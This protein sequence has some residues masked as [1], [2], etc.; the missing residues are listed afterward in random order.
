M[1]HTGGELLAAQLVAEG[2][3][4]VFG[5][6]GIQLDYAVDGLA[7][8]ADQIDF[9]VAR[10]EQG[11]AYM[12]DGYARVSD[13][14]GVCLVV[15][16][17]GL[18]NAGAALSTA[19]ATSSRVVMIVGQIPSP[20]I[21]AGLGMLH[22][23]PEQSRLIASLTKWHRLVTDAADIPAAVNEAFRQVQSGRPR[24]VAIEVPPDV[25]KTVATAP[26]LPAAVG[27]PLAPDAGQIA[28]LAAQLSAA[29]R[30]VIYVG[31]GIRDIPAATALQAVAEALGAPIV[32]SRNGRGAVS[33]RHPLAL[34]RLAG[35][36]ALDAA[37]F[38]LAV[39]TRFM[40]QQGR[41]VVHPGRHRIAAINAEAADLAAPRS[42]GLAL[43]ADARLA[44][45]ALLPQ[46]AP[47]T[48]AAAEGTPDP[49]ELR[50]RA[51]RLLDEVAP[52]RDW[53]LAIRAGLPDDGV[54]VDELTQVGYPSRIAY[55]VYTPGSYVTPG[56]QGTLGYGFPTALGVQAA[57]PDRP[58]VSINGDGGFGWALQEL[59]TAA[60]YRLGLVTIVFENGVFGNVERIQQETFG[61]TVGV[62]LHNPD[63]TLLGE[64]FGVA[65]RTV[66]T[67]D[68]LTAVIRDHAGVREPLLVVVPVTDFPTP[69]DLIA[70]PSYGDAN[71]RGQA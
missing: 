42:F 21:D 43:H 5:V 63:Y 70:E 10:H 53:L 12:A 58:V 66:R 48:A 67:P 20:T 56:Y 54:F 61:R 2:V 38:V 9:V 19:Y 16:G 59:S 55:P 57:D 14:P 64:A 41:P 11:A 60:K 37:D 47:R 33:D 26:I 1:T 32:M 69:W 50:E 62:D 31:G 40:T 68:E 35:G 46:L 4:K 65:V 15:P 22:E 8:H 71:G 27:E 29:E 13:K 28:D 52:Q 51:D 3:E 36:P 23:I 45:E 25:L 34:T 30:P 24:P 6:P 39:G 7:Q 49:A 18:L 44:L 17:P